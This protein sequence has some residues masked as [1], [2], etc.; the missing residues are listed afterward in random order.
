MKFLQLKKKLKLESKRFFKKI[1]LSKI[2]HKGFRLVMITII[3]TS[4]LYGVYAMF[5]KNLSDNVIVSESE[6]ISRVA[7]LVSLPNTKILSL[8]RVDNADVLRKQNDF[9]KDVKEGEY[10]LAYEKMIIIYDLR[11]DAIVAKK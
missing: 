3:V 5:N 7:K 4:A 9:Y 1:L 2:F 11:N 10:V 8:M 6:I